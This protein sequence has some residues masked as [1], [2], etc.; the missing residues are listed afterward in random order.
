MSL[1]EEVNA[2]PWF[3]S[4]DFGNGLVSPGL[5]NLDT[6]RAEAAAYFLE[7]LAGQSVLDIGCWDGYMSFEAAHRGAGRV[8]AT[9]HFVWRDDFH[10]PLHWPQHGPGRRREAFE[11]ARRHLAPQVEARD[12]DF[13]ELTPEAVGRF[14]IVLFA[15]I[16]YHL[17]DPLGGLRKAAALAKQTLIVETLLDGFETERP[18]MIYYPESEA[19]NDA[20]KRWGPNT[21]CVVAMLRDAGF[22]DIRPQPHP[23]IGGRGIFHATR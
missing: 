20:T 5:K 15:G 14:D 1:A 3:H 11:L 18:A 16:F 8:L 17:P 6:L 12:I 2:L 7:P 19:V 13:P 10:R 23:S 4:I 21:A 22:S 9:D